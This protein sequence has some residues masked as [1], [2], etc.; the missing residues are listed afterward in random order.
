MVRA[1]DLQLHAQGT[2]V[3]LQAQ[4]RDGST[5]T[6]ILQLFSFETGGPEVIVICTHPALRYDYVYQYSIGFHSL[7]KKKSPSG[8]PCFEVIR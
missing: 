1:P 4:R 8:V 7:K 3:G 6:I 2:P 5:S